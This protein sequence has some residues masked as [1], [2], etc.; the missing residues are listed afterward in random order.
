MP[1]VANVQSWSNRCWACRAKSPCKSKLR[2]IQTGLFS[3]DTVSPSK[4]SAARL[5]PPHHSQ[6]PSATAILRWLRRLV[7][8]RR[9][10]DKGGTNSTTWMPAARR[11]CRLGWPP[12]YRPKPSSSRRICRPWR[13]RCSSNAVMASPSTSRPRMKVQMSSVCRAPAISAC[14]RCRASLPLWWIASDSK[15]AAAPRPRALARCSCARAAGG[16]GGCVVRRVLANL[17]WP[18]KRYSGRAM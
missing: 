7:R 11:R 1:V 13:A 15:R 9:G 2:S 12:R 8:P 3:T 14:S 4:Y 5:R 18:N 6:V 16:E 17:R 10:E